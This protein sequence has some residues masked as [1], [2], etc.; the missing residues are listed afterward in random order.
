MS[1][2][3]HGPRAIAD[4]T[5]KELEVL[6]LLTAGHTIKSIATVLDRSEA[7]INER[8]RDARRKTGIGS[9]RELARLVA[10]QEN[11]PRKTDL[12]SPGAAGDAGEQDSSA[13]PHWKKGKIAMFTLL[14]LAAGLMLVATTSHRADEPQASQNAAATVSPLIG[15][16]SLDTARIP[17]EERPGSVTIAFSISPDRQ[18]TTR[19]DIVAPDGNVMNASSTAA[20]DGVAVPISGNIPIYDTASLRQPAPNTLVMTLGKAGAPVATRVYTVARDGRSMTETIVWADKTMPK[21]E[22]TYFNRVG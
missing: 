2:T 20:T 11:W 1:A 3:D 16:W 10:G 12:P 8:L 19:V 14:P 5:D 15:K 6:R 18:W 22:T 21:M 4:L 7:S 17:E 9:S 13:R